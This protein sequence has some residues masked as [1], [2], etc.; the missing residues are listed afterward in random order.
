MPRLCIARSDSCA[1]S[2]SHMPAHAHRL[3]VGDAPGLGLVEH[4][5]DDGDAGRGKAGPWRLDMSSDSLS[6]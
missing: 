1:A 5:Q 2:H 6:L 4:R 3:G